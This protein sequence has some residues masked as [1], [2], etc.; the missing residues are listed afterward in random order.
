MIGRARPAP[1][2]RGRQPGVALVLALAVVAL[3]A[4]AASA[5][6]HAQ[7]GWLRVESLRS[8]RA[9]ALAAA[10][11]ALDWAR[12]A[13][14]RDARATGVDHRLEPWAAHIGPLEV[15]GA[16]VSGW[17][18]DAQGAFN[19]NGI[20]P[21]GR[22]LPAQLDRYRRLLAVLGLPA[23]LADALADWLDSDA[24]ASGPDG[25]ED[26]FYLALA[27]PYLAANQPL[28]E[29]GELARVRGYDAQV[30]ERLR[31]HVVAL[32][33]ATAVNVNTATPEVLCALLPGS[34]LGA[35]RALVLERE[36][37]PFRSL[38][39]F[40]A[41][42]GDRGP[43]SLDGLAVGSAWFIAQ[44]RVRAGEVVVSAEALLSRAATGAPSIVWR[45]RG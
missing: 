22:V 19:L 39:D 5:I 42:A 29:R 37:R 24:R 14:A 16:T 6:L 25:A 41:R 17:L 40:A 43:D 18:D 9:Q 7:S 12:E 13:L 34:D 31:P 10:D 11:A 2:C 23:G 33:V 4:A 32:P 21:Q 26:A 44:V 30:L 27:A 36:R 28:A 1:V 15:E 3:A 8:D 38:A 45:R 20:A 35:A